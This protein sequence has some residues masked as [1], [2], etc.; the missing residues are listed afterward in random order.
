MTYGS[1]DF[2]FL[3]DPEKLIFSHF[4]EDCDWQLLDNPKQLPDFE[5]QAFIKRHFFKLGSQHFC[6]FSVYSRKMK[7]FNK[8]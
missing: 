8:V 1:D 3:S 6:N 5:K 7:F 2:Y 4:P